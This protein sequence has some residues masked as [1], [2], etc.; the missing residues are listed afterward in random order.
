MAITPK[1]G[2]MID[3][4]NPNGVIP[5]GSAPVLSV[6]SVIPP[7]PSP[8]TATPSSVGLSSYVP[9]V[10]A[11]QQ[12]V[13]DAQKAEVDRKAA[14]AT[15]ESE[16]E[17]RARITSGFQSEIDALNAVYAQQK[18][19]AIQRGMGRLGSDAAIQARRG[20]IGSTFGAGQ[21]AN[22]ESANAADVQAVEAEKAAAL[23]GVYKRIQEAV[24][25]DAKDK[26]AAMDESA[27]TFIEYKKGEVDR[28]AKLAQ[29]LIQNMIAG[30]AKPTEQDLND[31]AKSIGVDPAILKKDYITAAQAKVAELQK[32]KQEVLK[33]EQD[34]QKAQQEIGK[35][36]SVG[37]YTWVFQNGQWVNK[38]QNKVVQSPGT[39]G[40]TTRQNVVFNS[41]MSKSNAVADASTT[42]NVAKA[43][44]QRLIDDPTNAQTQLSNLYQYVKVLDSNSA[45]REGETQLAKDTG[46]LLNKLQQAKQSIESGSIVGSDLAVKMANEAIAL[47][48]AW[49]AESDKKQ[50]RLRAQ[51]RAN[52]I[53]Q[54]FVDTLDYGNQLNSQVQIP[55]SG[56]MRSP[57]GTQ[58]VNVSDLTPAEIAEAKA[59]GWQ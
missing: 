26:K 40:M 21:T 20:L 19:E 7:T 22:V 33:A 16:S 30:M 31:V 5:I 37:D 50:N 24:S 1:P 18:Q 39:E 46:S 15:P 11:D 47:S 41:I 10:S 17:R 25:Q 53:E 43:T 2:Y 27:Q 28:K 42:F 6:G 52:G 8:A 58:E 32:Q 49:Q 4:N 34:A 48:N 55:T 23:A 9:Q 54:Q 51:A 59:A 14:L 3:P 38:G 35:P 13:Y 56:V 36:V 44:A 57:D 12:A 45:V 29:E